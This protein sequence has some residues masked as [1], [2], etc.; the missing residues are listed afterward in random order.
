ML[1][2]VLR[3]LQVCANQPWPFRANLQGCLGCTW[4]CATGQL[5]CTSCP[6]HCPPTQYP[7]QDTIYGEDKG[8]YGGG[9]GGEHPYGE[10]NEQE[11][12]QEG[13]QER[14]Q[15][16]Y[17]HAPAE[18]QDRPGGYGGYGGHGGDEDED[19]DGGAHG[20][21]R[22]YDGEE[23]TDSPEH[24]EATA[25]SWADKQLPAA[26]KAQRAQPAQQSAKGS[27]AARSRQVQP[28]A[29]KGTEKGAASKGGRGRAG[30]AKNA[31]QQVQPKSVGP[32]SKG[33]A[34]KS[35]VKGSA[36]KSS[37]AAATNGT[38][39]VA[40]LWH[41]L[42]GTGSG[43]HGRQ[44]DADCTADR[45]QCLCGPTPFIVPAQC[46]LVLYDACDNTLQCSSDGY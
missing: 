21:K 14:E 28:A 43:R 12:E 22:V 24:Q 30:S 34:E 11:Q 26:D 20:H 9:S 23:D 16:R 8:T 19:A 18:G 35:G 46:T 25:A 37:S 17:E 31:R 27:E 41:P 36:K 4:S 10:E 15:D 1:H 2:T 40:A 44:V 3:A 33:S 38:V 29:V 6:C 42:V 7:G 13:E 5:S 39:S 32:D 45:P